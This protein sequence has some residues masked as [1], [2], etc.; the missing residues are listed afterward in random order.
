MPYTAKEDTASK[1]NIE[2]GV[3]SSATVVLNGITNHNNILLNRVNTGAIKYKK[4]FALVGI[5]ISLRN[6]FKPSAIG[7]K[8][9]KKPAIFGPLLLCTLPI[10][11]RSNNVVNAIVNNKNTKRAK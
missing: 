6:N 7:C 8:N 4:R 10:T 3:S 9:P 2:F 11:F 5:I 1:N